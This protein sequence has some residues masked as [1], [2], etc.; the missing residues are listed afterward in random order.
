MV[1]LEEEEPTLE[2]LGVQDDD[3]VLLEVRNKDLTW[4]EEMGA[5]QQQFQ[6][7]RQGEGEYLQLGGQQCIDIGISIYSTY[8]KRCYR[9]QQFGQHMFHECCSTVCQ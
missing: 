6:Q 3:A 1:L 2:E 9:T 8:R 5:I 4:P 7:R